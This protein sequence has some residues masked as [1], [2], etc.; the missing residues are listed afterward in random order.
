MVHKVL[1]SVLIV[2]LLAPP[3]SADEA[4]RRLQSALPTPTRDA[5]HPYKWPGLIMVGVG[6]LIS[7]AA[8]YGTAGIEGADF[9]SCRADAVM[10]GADNDCQRERLANPSLLALGVGLMGGG[11]LIGLHRPARTPHITIG[12]GRVS[13]S[14]RVS[15]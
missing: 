9:R 14:G 6:G 3:V 8:M 5:G 1:V 2:A 4:A 15:F 7:L 10:R 12:H 11:L 13:V